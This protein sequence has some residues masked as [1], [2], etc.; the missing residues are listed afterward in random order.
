[1]GGLASLPGRSGSFPRFRP[2]NTL[3]PWALFEL[4]LDENS[5]I[6]DRTGLVGLIFRMVTSSFSGAVIS[7]AGGT[8]PV[9]GMI[10]GLVGGVIGT[11]GGFHLRRASVLNTKYSDT[12]V[13]ITEDLIAIGIGLACV[14]FA[15]RTSP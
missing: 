5:K 9:M 2:R 7:S 6:G 13:A 10:A 14:Y 8:E 1:M 11:Y 12:R 15:G 4:V 3:A